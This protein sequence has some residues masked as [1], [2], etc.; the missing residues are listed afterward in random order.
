M[1]MVEVV[2][3]L[4]K[5][6]V[7]PWLFEYTVPIAG[8]LW[9]SEWLLPSGAKLTEPW[10][11]AEYVEPFGK[12]AVGIGGMLATYFLAPEAYK[13]PLY[14]LSTVPIAMGGLEALKIALGIGSS[15]KKKGSPEKTPPHR[16]T[17]RT[18]VSPEIKTYG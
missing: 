13:M 15:P 18:V 7:P 2:E 11:P 4:K 9:I 8:G 10:A 16:Q 17:G 1:K 3:V 5:P 6:F 12:I 14:V